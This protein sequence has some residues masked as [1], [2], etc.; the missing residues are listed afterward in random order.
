MA[1]VKGQ[2]T[3]VQLEKDK[4]RGKCRKWQLRA[5][6]GLDPRTGKYKTRTRRFCGTYTEAKSA[7]RDFIAEVEDN[8]VVTRSGTTFKECADD[9]MARRIASGNY[10]DNTNEAYARYFKAACRHIGFAEVTTID[11]KT[12]ESMYAAMR[13]GDTLSGKPSSGTT[14][15]LL[16]KTIKLLMDNLVAG[17][18]IVENP[19]LNV[20]TPPRDTKERRALKPARI[21]SFINE[22]D[23]ESEP[24]CGYFLAIALG[25][26]RAEVCGLSWEDVDFDGMAISIRHSYDHFRNLKGPKTKASIRT[27]PMATFVARALMRHKKAQAA[28]L[29]GV[30][31]EGGRPVKQ[32][33]ESPVILDRKF[34]RMNPNDFAV[35]WRQDRGALGVE[36]WC[37]HELR[38]SYL[39]MLALEGV[40]P[41]V[42]QDLAG[43][44]D[45]S[46][47]MDIYTHVNM[48]Q[49]RCAADALEALLSG[50]EPSFEPA[51]QKPV[52]TVIPGAKNQLP[53][54]QQAAQG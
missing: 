21:R 51:A 1:Q 53:E 35:A 25:L 46:T 26:R 30:V 18:V 7:L 14:L 40:H 29:E 15:H 32:T 48:D 5:S 38:H 10:T 41:K 28:A 24:E 33:E 49:K 42:K 17:G 9:F 22:L 6:V 27:L 52:F 23:V 45:F 20:T 43:H 36:G 12:L 16:H 31:D 34:R 3:I 11:A 19:R 4:P 2:G 13:Q 44:A 37:L 8:K 50:S 54:S 39:S 47:T